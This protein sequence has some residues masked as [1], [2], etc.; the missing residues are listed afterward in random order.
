[1][2]KTVGPPSPYSGKSAVHQDEQPGCIGDRYR[3]GK[4]NQ[5]YDDLAGGSI[6]PESRLLKHTVQRSCVRHR[7]Y[8]RRCSYI[9]GSYYD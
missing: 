4:H 8:C 5:H 6:E 7:A 3:E 2:T 9:F 1:M